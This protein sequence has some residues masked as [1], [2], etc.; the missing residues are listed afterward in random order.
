MKYINLVL[1]LIFLLFAAWQ[2]NDPDPILWITIYCI[3]AYCALKAYL[4]SSNKELLTILIIIS[5]AAAINSW[6]QMT[7]WEGVMPEG[8]SMKTL[9]QELAR[10][11][12][13]L[14][15]CAIS[16]L[17]FFVFRKK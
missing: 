12:L 6:T 4:G 14:G 3:A 8:L 10:E 9:N 15:I 13:G 11:S 17:F 16:F 5:T 1:F 2:Y 7:A